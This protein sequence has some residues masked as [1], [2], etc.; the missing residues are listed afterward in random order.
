MNAELKVTLT[1]NGTSYSRVVSVRKLLCE[2]LRETI[3]ISP[4]PMSAA[5]TASVVPAQY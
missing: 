3:S 4:E 2:F 1:V 5:S